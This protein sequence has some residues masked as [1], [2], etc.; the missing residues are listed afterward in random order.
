MRRAEIVKMTRMYSE[1]IAIA[2]YDG[3]SDRLTAAQAADELLNITKVQASFVIYKS[4]DFTCISA[5][6]LGNINVQ[7]ILEKLG[8]GGHLATAGAQIKNSTIQHV[9]DQLISAINQVTNNN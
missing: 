7:L 3:E 2:M 6:S 1:N 5:R 8:G 4:R 9:Y